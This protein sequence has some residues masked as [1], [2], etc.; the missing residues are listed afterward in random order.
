MFSIFRITE[1]RGVIRQEH[2]RLSSDSYTFIWVRFGQ[3]EYNFNGIKYSCRRNELLLIPPGCLGFELG[4][5]GRLRELIT[6]QFSPSASEISGMLPILSRRAPLHWASAMPEL[7]LEKL[8]RLTEQW[9]EHQSYFTMMCAALLAEVLVLVSREVDEGLKKPSTIQHTDR[10]K[11]YIE[12]HYREKITKQELGAATGISPNYA[13]AMFRKVT[14]LTISEYVH[15]KRMKTA[16]YLLRH[17]QLTVQEISEQLG[18]ADPS[19][20]HRTFKRLLGKLP[21]DLMNERTDRD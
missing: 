4:G 7:M 13:A 18:Y 11:R 16:Q 10:M 17:S 1:E 3:S 5:K 12:D 8:L 15:L 9:T 6:I 19:Y 20:F 14:G 21:S 2:R